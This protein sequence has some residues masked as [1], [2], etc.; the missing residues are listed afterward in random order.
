MQCGLRDL[1]WRELSVGRELT[2][3]WTDRKLWKISWESAV[4]RERG[5]SETEAWTDRQ[6][7]TELGD[8][9]EGTRMRGCIRI[10]LG[11]LAAWEGRKPC[12]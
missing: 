8:R 11:K 5:G 4:G 3:V 9:W 7:R 2:E 10:V 12:H 1:P 6:P